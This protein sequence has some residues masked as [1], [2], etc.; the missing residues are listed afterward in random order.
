MNLPFMILVG[1]MISS[2]ILIDSFIDEFNN[3][4]FLKYE[5]K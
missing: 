2:V 1:S 4:V 3:E 5:K